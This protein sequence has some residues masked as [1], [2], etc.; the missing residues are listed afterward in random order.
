[1]I[2]LSFQEPCRLGLASWEY[3]LTACVC[4]GGGVRQMGR[5]KRVVSPYAGKEANCSSA[6]EL[7]FGK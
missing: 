2:Q 4:G 5:V 6:E 7:R 1:M 3:G